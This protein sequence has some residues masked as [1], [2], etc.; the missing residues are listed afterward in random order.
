M[1]TYHMYYALKTVHLCSTERLFQFLTRISYAR[2]QQ[3]VSVSFHEFDQD[4][5]R[6]FQVLRT[7]T[8]LEHIKFHLPGCC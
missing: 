1:E 8:R 4:A 3:L 6:A 5:E 2:R 7:A